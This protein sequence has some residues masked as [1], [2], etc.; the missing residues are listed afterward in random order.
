MEIRSYSNDMN[1]QNYNLANKPQLTEKQ[2]FADLEEYV[3][4]LSNP[5]KELSIAG[6]F[7]WFMSKYPDDSSSFSK[8]EIEKIITKA[9]E[10]V[11]IPI[12]G[13]ILSGRRDITL[14]N[15]QSTTPLP[16]PFD[17]YK[18]QING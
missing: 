10:L 11:G 15:P 2:I 18:R 12:S 4:S 7:E 13:P 16:S 5:Q 3:K 1:D 14:E 17:F 6:V 8:E 9:F